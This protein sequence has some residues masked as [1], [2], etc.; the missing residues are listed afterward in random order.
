MSSVGVYPSCLP[1][2]IFATFLVVN[3]VKEW[4]R[5][6]LYT[7]YERLYKAGSK[8]GLHTQVGIEVTVSLI[9]CSITTKLTLKCDFSDSFCQGN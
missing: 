2:K 8:I 7:T 5:G 6:M 9:L 4:G 1:K 3:R